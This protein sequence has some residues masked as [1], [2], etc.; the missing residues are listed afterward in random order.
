MRSRSLGA[1]QI[2][3]FEYLVRR[4]AAE[5]YVALSI[6]INADN[7]FGFGEPNHIERL[8]QLVDL[9]LKAL[10]T[11]SDGGSN[12]FGV[13]LPAAPTCDGWHSSVTRRGGKAHI[14]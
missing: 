2:T 3:R 11:A 5:G 14:F 9:H 8:R 6:N 10:G 12:Q 7:T 1:A 4:L 13:D